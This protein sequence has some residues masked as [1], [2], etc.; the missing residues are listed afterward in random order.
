[1]AADKGIVNRSDKAAE[2]RAEWE[3]RGGGGDQA[4]ARR[5]AKRR[6]QAAASAR[7]KSGLDQGGGSEGGA[8]SG[9]E[10]TWKLEAT[11]LANRLDM[12]WKRKSPLKENA[13]MA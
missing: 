13:K 4:G 7:H 8:R 3:D 2:L 6:G 11:R 9:A 10:C 5:P 1:M 12:G